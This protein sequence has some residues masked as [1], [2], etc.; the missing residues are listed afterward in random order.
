MTVYYKSD[1]KIN[2]K[3]TYNVESVVSILERDNLNPELPDWAS[4]I[5]RES[6]LTILRAIIYNSKKNG[7]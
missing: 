5:R 1:K 3:T 6:R 2:D 7:F 4:I